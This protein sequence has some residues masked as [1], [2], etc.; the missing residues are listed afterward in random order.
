MDISKLCRQDIEK[1]CAYC[2]FSA[3]SFKGDNILCKKYGAVEKTH[4]CKRFK[5]NPLK[6]KPPSRVQIRK[7]YD[8]GGF[9][10]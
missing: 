7:N 9:G 6:R 8:F 4:T 10:E 3:T 2:E 5:Y 1:I